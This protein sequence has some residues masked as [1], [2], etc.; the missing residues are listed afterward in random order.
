M[1]IATIK[2]LTQQDF[3]NAYNLGKYVYEYLEA[4]SQKTL[5]KKTNVLVSKNHVMQIMKEYQLQLPEDDWSFTPQD[6]LDPL[7][8]YDLSSNNV[9]WTGYF[10]FAILKDLHHPGH[11]DNDERKNTW[12]KRLSDAFPDNPGYASSFY[13]DVVSL[14]K[15]GS[16][17]HDFEETLKKSYYDTYGKMYE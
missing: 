15:A 6:V 17:S 9:A 4:N 16:V 12:I 14:K 3:K 13:N 8:S 1:Y 2:E 7:E 11:H 5:F 10:A